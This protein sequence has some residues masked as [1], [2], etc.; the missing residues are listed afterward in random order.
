[1]NLVT[2]TME[3]TPDGAANAQQPP[4]GGT[5]AP[6]SAGAPENVQGQPR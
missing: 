5:A 2:N 4:P 3:P 6:T 1:M